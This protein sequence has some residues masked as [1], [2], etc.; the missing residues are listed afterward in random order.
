MPPHQRIGNALGEVGHLSLAVAFQNLALIYLCSRLVTPMVADFCA[1]AAVTLVFDFVYHLT[2][3]V[4]VLSVDVQRMELSDSLERVDLS[5]KAKNRNGRQSWLAALREGNTPLSTRFAGTVAIFSIILA[6]NWH[7]FDIG[8]QGL[9]LHTLRKR[10]MSKRQKR[11]QQSLW[12]APP[13]NQARTPADWLRLQDHNIARE[14]FERFKPGAHSFVA[15]IY[16]PILVVAKGAQGR[17]KIQSPSSLLEHLR[18][19]ARGHAFP[20][21]LMSVLIIAGVTLLLNYLLWSGLPEDTDVDEEVDASF[22]VKTLSTPHVLDVVSMSS[23]SKGHLV[24]IS[25]DR[26]TSIWLHGRTG[27]LHTTLHTASMKPKLWPIIAS[28]LDDNGNSLALCAG[29]GQ[30]GLWSI[31]ASRFVIFPTVDLRGQTPILFSFVTI[32]RMEIEKL[33]LMI[34]TPDGYLTELEAHTGIHRTKRISSSS[35][36]C[37]KLYVCVKGNVSLVFV[38]KPGEVHILPLQQLNNTTSEVVASLDPGPPPD[39]NPSKVKCIQGVPSLGLIVALRDERAELFDFA[40]RA[41]IHAFEIGHVKAH[42]FR[43]MHS[44]RRQCSCG[45]P[46]VHS[47]AVAYSEQETNHMIMQSFN[48]DHTTNPQIC[49]GKPPDRNKYNC[50]GLERAIQDVYCVEP[51]GVWESTNLLSVVGIRRCIISSPP[52]SSASDDDEDETP[53][54]F[55]GPTSSL[56]QRAKLRGTPLSHDTPDADSWEAWTLSSTGEF[57]SRPLLPSDDMDSADSAPAEDD[58]LVAAPGPIMRLGK[59]SIAVG[60]GNTVKIVTLGKELFD[61]TARGAA[62][63]SA[64]DVGRGSA[65]KW[66]A[67]RGGRGKIH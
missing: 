50:Q 62:E 55:T 60:F 53:P 5:Q 25:L 58:L 7:F 14:L 65:Y 1:F 56:K 17:E 44:A 23:C 8:D 63:G 37:A 46:A 51:A 19:F 22:S 39:S 4:A 29:T 61:G 6:I 48:L 64:L 43:V 52:S 40:S 66:R 3:F 35:I 54:H 15:R 59:K 28:A 33:C 13:I 20:A 16:D 38:C 26:S 18:R 45:A 27:Y 49:L 10:L 24:S 11:G 30:I 2:F 9:S 67:K 12:S 21:A 31:T 57:R 41:L 36:L 34:V 32:T 42:S 47:L